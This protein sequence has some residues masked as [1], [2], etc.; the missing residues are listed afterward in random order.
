MSASE[1]LPN[2]I[3]VNTVGDNIIETARVIRK[4]KNKKPPTSL[5]EIADECILS[6]N[7]MGPTQ[8]SFD[9]FCGQKGLDGMMVNF[10]VNKIVENEKIN[11]VIQKGTKTIDGLLASKSIFKNV[12]G[13]AAR[14]VLPL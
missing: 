7:N 1:T 13:I 11:A 8:A 10:A 9:L 3:T 12:L 2:D 4:R 14:V 6:V 5:E